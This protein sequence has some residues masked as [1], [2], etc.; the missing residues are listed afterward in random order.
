M[1]K[2]NIKPLGARVLV[3]PETAEEKTSSGIV[4]PDTASK[5]KP[6]RG[7]VLAV[8]AEQKDVKKGDTVIFKKYAPTEIK[9]DNEE[10]YILDEEDVLA[11][12]A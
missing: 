4:L 9:I 6:Q 12:I 11:V 8:G 1:T 5:E 2:T 3:R 7:T 10:L